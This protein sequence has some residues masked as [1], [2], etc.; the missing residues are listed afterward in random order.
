MFYHYM[1]CLIATSN[2]YIHKKENYLPINVW[3]KYVNLIVKKVLM[4]PTSGQQ[5]RNNHEHT[6]QWKTELSIFLI[7]INLLW[8]TEISKIWVIICELKN[9]YIFYKNRSSRPEAPPAT[10]LKKRLW[11]RCFPVNF[12]KF[13]RTPLFIKHLWWLLF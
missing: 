3:A 1:K 2:V 9:E 7:F 13:L 12:A 8:S 10:L 5:S 4:Q 11:H 6:T